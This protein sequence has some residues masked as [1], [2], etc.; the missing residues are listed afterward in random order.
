M[1]KL[2]DNS[3]DS[4]YTII[5]DEA[6]S[7]GILIWETYVSSEEFMIISERF[8]QFVR[9]KRCTSIINDSTRASHISTE[10]EQKWMIEDYIPRL[11]ATGIRYSA[12]VLPANKL[13]K[14]Q[15]EDVVDTADHATIR[16]QYFSNIGEAKEWLAS[17]NNQ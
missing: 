8:L 4:A 13:I 11:I 1:V 3:L 5:Y 16:T 12:I 2:L 14:L 9:E 7:C 10:A 15:I 6:L 17:F